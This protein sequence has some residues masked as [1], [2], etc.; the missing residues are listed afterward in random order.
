MITRKIIA[1]TIQ[2]FVGFPT[3][4]FLSIF[5]PHLKLSLRFDLAPVHRGQNFSIS[6]HQLCIFQDFPGPLSI[7][8]E[9]GGKVDKRD[10]LTW[11][12]MWWT[13]SKAK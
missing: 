1:L 3:F 4:F 6:K 10:K 8:W 9:V 7:A 5:L 2:T 12:W 13:E 11:E